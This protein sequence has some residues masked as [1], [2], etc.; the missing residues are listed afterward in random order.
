MCSLQKIVLFVRFHK[1][2]WTHSIILCIISSLL[3]GCEWYTN[4]CRI[5]VNSCYVYVGECK[6]FRSSVCSLV[7]GKEQVL[8]VQLS[9]MGFIVLHVAMPGTGTRCDDI[10]KFCPYLVAN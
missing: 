6:E 2:N 7:R 4:V 1:L 5:P 9:V 3:K 10:C 8:V